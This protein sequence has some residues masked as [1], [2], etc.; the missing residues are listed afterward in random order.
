M[1]AGHPKVATRERCCYLMDNAQVE[2][3]F[4]APAQM[5]FGLPTQRLA[6]GI[7]LMQQIYRQEWTDLLVV[8]SLDY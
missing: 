7:Q 6:F 5:I 1:S 8:F 3:R 4:Q 2:M